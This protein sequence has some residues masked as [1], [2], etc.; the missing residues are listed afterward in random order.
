MKLLILTTESAHHAYFVRELQ[1]ALG[2]VTVFLETQEQQSAFD[3][4]H[5]FEEMRDE[6]ESRTWFG[7]KRAVVSDY[8]PATRFGS[9]NEEAAVAAIRRAGADL[10]VVFGTSRLK[11]SVIGACPPTLLNLHGGDPENYRGLDSHLWAI[12]HRDFD[13]IMTTMHRVDT[14]LDTG[15]IVS[16][17]KVPIGEGMPLHALRAENTEMCVQLTVAATNVFRRSGQVTSRPQ[18]KVGRYYSAMPASLKSIC[19]QNF[20]N[21]IGR[22]TVYEA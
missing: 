8:A 2:S 10:V 16:Q 15:E 19:E 18:R 22:L 4:H 13:G 14:E 6:Y 1:E 5:P 11:R 3:T 17:A 12:Y 9:L 20:A 7:G 21:F